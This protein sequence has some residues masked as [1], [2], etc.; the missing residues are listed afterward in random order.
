MSDH[1]VPRASAKIQQIRE[2][3][4]KQLSPE[5]YELFE[6]LVAQLEMHGMNAYLNSELGK[7]IAKVSWEL[8]IGEGIDPDEA[9]QACDYAFLGNELKQMCRDAGL[10]PGGDKK[11]MCE[12]LYRIGYEPVVAIMKPIRDRQAREAQGIK[13][14]PEREP[15]EVEG[16]AE[17]PPE[18]I[19]EGW[20][21]V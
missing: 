13:P 4:K 11:T 5:D 8:E 15:E 2:A 10:S 3:A 18:D 19:M 1:I 6:Q 9:R 7:L 20:R 17:P 21:T 16:T 12:R 14:P